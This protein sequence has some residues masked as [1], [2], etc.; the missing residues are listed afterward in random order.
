MALIQP[1]ITPVLDANG[2]VVTGA[3]IYA[4][5]NVT[6]ADTCAP[7]RVPSMADKSIQA[8]FN[9]GTPTWGV[10]GSNDPALATY[11]PLNDPQGNALTAIATAKIEQLLEN[12]AA[13]RPATP[14]GTS[15]NVTF[16]LMGYAAARRG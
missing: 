10:E 8:V 16:F 1:V 13:V 14:G 11:Q 5:Q 3:F 2:S 6:A 9:S 12:V 7:A 4:W 15:P